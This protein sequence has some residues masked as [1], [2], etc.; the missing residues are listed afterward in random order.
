M[1]V[2]ASRYWS[3]SYLVGFAIGIFLA[4]PILTRTEFIGPI[5]W[6]LYDGTA[7]GAMALRIKIHSSKF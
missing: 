4:L 2:D 5:D 1:T 3:F 6:L 7:L